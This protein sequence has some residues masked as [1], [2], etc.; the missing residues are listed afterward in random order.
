MDTNFM[1]SKKRAYCDLA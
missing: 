1:I